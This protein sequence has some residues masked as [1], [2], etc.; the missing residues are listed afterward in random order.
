MGKYIDKF[1]R[2]SWRSAVRLSV[3]GKQTVCGCEGGAGGRGEI[4]KLSGFSLVEGGEI[5]WGEDNKGRKRKEHV[6]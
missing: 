3:V 2:P 6:L 5:G 4:E 1:N